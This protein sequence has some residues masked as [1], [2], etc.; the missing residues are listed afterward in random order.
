MFFVEDELSDLT[1]FAGKK[2]SCHSLTYWRPPDDSDV[3]GWWRW[4]SA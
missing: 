2:P 4:F 1:K 3:P